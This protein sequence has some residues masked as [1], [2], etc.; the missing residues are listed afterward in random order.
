M[1]ADDVKCRDIFADN[2][3]SV[4]A[5]KMCMS[6]KLL[7]TNEMQTGHTQQQNL[8]SVILDD[9]GQMIKMNE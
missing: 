7:G 3:L 4:L 2:K 9:E 8:E 5:A 1:F 6:L